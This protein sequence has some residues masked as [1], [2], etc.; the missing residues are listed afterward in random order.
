MK[1]WHVQSPWRGWG[2]LATPVLASQ[3]N[4]L[5]P[6]GNVHTRKQVCLCVTERSTW[7]LENTSQPH[8]HA[9]LVQ[10]ARNKW[11]SSLLWRI[12]PPCVGFLV[13]GGQISFFF[14]KAFSNFFI[15]Y[16][17]GRIANH[18]ESTFIQNTRSAVEH[19]QE[20]YWD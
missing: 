4:V 1:H 20:N 8:I 19:T 14:Y 7:G 18:L 11:S 16:R 17:F 6:W 5:I 2:N 12:H 10:D 9:G 13:P 3:Q 15:I